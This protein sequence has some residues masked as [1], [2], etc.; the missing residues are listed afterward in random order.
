MWTDSNGD[1]F[2]VGAIYCTD[3]GNEFFFATESAYYNGWG[4]F[5]AVQDP[6]ETWPD[7]Q[8]VSAWHSCYFSN[9][10][11]TYRP[12]IPVVYTT[13]YTG[14][15]RRNL[16]YPDDAGILFNKYPLRGRTYATGI[17]P[18]RMYMGAGTQS[19]GHVY[20]DGADTYRRVT[21]RLYI[22]MN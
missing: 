21:D 22:K 10:Q 11:L 12:Q 19:W 16:D 13:A 8:Q 14:A 3:P 1:G 2:L 17:T 18:D 6:S 20:Q 15:S 7:H 4:I 9:S 5:K